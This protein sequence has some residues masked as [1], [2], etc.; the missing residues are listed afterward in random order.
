MLL[1]L[2]ACATAPSVPTVGNP[3]IAAPLPPVRLDDRPVVGLA[4]GGGAARGF[5][6]VGVLN[7]LDQHGIPVD[8]V[9]G[10][11]A[12]GVAGA[13]YAAGIR[14]DGL[15]EAA[16]RLDRDQITDWRFPN[17]GFI[18]GESLQELINTLVD[19]RPIEA[20]GTVFAAVASDL[21]TGERVAF[22]R[23]NTGL[24]VR[25]SSSVPGIVQPVT[26]NGRE[27]VDGG[28]VSQVPVE[29]AR[30]L[31]AD[32]VIAVDVTK[33]PDPEAPLDSTLAVMHQAMLILS[34][35][36]ADAETEKA[37]YV[38]RPDVNQVSLADFDLRAYAIAQGELAA[39]RA[40]GEIKLLIAR[41]TADRRRPTG[42]AP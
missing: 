24:A 36:Q 18:A 41:K 10:T 33:L 13:L 34:K 39:E 31:G 30:E 26:I 38:I 20:L 22:T 21:R 25:A 2:S 40:A 29:V 27:Y 11:S 17:R 6:H 3:P 7:K 4:L 9:V 15:M 35:V 12:G 28:L 19:N 8:L 37:D 32:I 23:G 16:R 42:T 5:A 14:G 1:A